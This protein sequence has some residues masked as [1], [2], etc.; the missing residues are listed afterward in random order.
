MFGKIK[1][2]I[3]CGEA[4]NISKVWLVFLCTFWSYTYFAS[5][6]SLQLLKVQV[7]YLQGQVQK[8]KPQQLYLLFSILLAL[9]FARLG[10]LFQ[11]NINLQQFL[12]SAGIIPSRY[13]IF[14]RYIYLSLPIF[15]LHILQLCC[16]YYFLLD[17][18][19]AT[20]GQLS[21][22]LLF[23]GYFINKTISRGERPFIDILQDRRYWVIHLIT[24]PSL[25]L[26]GVIFIFSGF[27]Y[28]LFG[29]ANFN[30][31]FLHDNT[32]ISLM[33][34]RFSILNEIEDV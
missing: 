26:A 21:F 1:V 25:F 2:K 32:Q 19:L 5:V 11:Q 27:V 29:V 22:F 13:S 18:L 30:Q 7:Y 16:N 20:E 17:L 4:S 33:N 24:I 14:C 34:D 9:T 12:F 3:K 10:S 23:L 31:Y 6:Y 15:Q 8:L 28:K